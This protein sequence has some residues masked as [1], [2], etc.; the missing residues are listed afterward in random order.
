MVCGFVEYIKEEIF[1]LYIGGKCSWILGRP[2]IKVWTILISIAVP[3]LQHNS[4]SVC[5]SQCLPPFSTSRVDPESASH[6]RA[7]ILESA[8]L[9][10]CQFQYRRDL[11]ERRHQVAGG[12]FRCLKCG[13]NFED[14]CD[15]EKH[16]RGGGTAGCP[17]RP[18]TTAGTPQ[19]SAAAAASASP[20]RHDCNVC[21]ATFDTKAAL[22]LHSVRHI[23]EQVRKENRRVGCFH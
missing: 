20:A 19:P 3:G 15:L 9:E 6:A 16:V 18:R 8:F 10:I 21:S 5:P 4:L 2:G 11:H 7:R 13:R 1:E 17:G 23:K 14:K 12:L 22:I